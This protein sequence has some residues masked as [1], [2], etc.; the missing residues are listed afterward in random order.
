MTTQKQEKLVRFI[1][2]NIGRTMIFD[3]GT[4]NNIPCIKIRNTKGCTIH[5]DNAGNYYIFNKKDR[6]GTRIKYITNIYIS[7]N[8]NINSI[9]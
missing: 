2:H 1:K 8:N 3:L 6:W 5:K 4:I 7:F 9:Q